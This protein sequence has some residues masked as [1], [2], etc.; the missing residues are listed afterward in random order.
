MT[1]QQAFDALIAIT[2]WT[3]LIF[4]AVSLVLGSAFVYRVLV[5]HVQRLVK[6]GVR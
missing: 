5:E 2:V 6:R 1:D 4:V 3:V